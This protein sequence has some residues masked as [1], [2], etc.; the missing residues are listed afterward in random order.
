MFFL[1]FKIDTL[2]FRRF[3]G[4][5]SNR[6]PSVRSVDLRIDVALVRVSEN[7]SEGPVHR[8]GG[9]IETVAG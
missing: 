7:P 8:F 6:V 9:P 3:T 5:Y 2:R 4:G 1:H